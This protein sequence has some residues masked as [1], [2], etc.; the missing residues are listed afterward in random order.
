MD[1]AA[2]VALALV[3]SAF[4]LA[5]GC[6]E[7]GE[8]SPRPP[9]GNGAEDGGIVPGLDGSTPDDGGDGGEDRPLAQPSIT[10]AQLSPGLWEITIDQ[11]EFMLSDGQEGTYCVRLPMPEILKDKSL[12]MVGADSDLPI[13]THHYFMAY[14]RNTRTQIEPCLPDEGALLPLEGE[15]MEMEDPGQYL[16]GFGVSNGMV[17]GDLTPGFGLYMSPNGH[18]VT[19]HHVL[20]ISGGPLRMHGRFKFRVK[21]AHEVPRIMRPLNCLNQGIRVE[22][23]QTVDV[24]ATCVA[25]FPIEIVQLGSHAHQHLDVIK[26]RVFRGGMVNP[27]YRDT[28]KPDEPNVVLGKELI[29]MAYRYPVG[30]LDWTIA[31]LA[32]PLQRHPGES[33]ESFFDRVR[34]VSGGSVQS[35][36]IY[37]STEWDAP[38]GIDRTTNPIR[39]AP[40]DGLTYTCTYTNPKTVPVIYGV[41]ENE[42]MCA[43]M[44]LY[45]LPEGTTWTGPSVDPGIP[46]SLANIVNWEPNYKDTLQPN[47]INVLVS[48]DEIRK[49]YPGD[50]AF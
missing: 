3:A 21:E 19:N 29:M 24:T 16:A 15:A 45:A 20:N 9:G 50:F 7:G 14:S 10:A 34:P 27:D 44:N 4:L 5:H 1:K 41:H 49:V 31:D 17:G 42:E 30:I 28:P 22:P 39:L 12:A 36:V 46:P 48:S 38:K 37:E 33:V 32:F 43:T 26:V 13:G 23:G 2:K 35:E 47:T 25:T 11:G 18:F 40:G 8:L 6:A